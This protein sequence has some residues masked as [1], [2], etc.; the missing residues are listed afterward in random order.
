MTPAGIES[1]LGQADA[2]KGLKTLQ[3]TEPNSGCTQT[4]GAASQEDV[5]PLVGRESECAVLQ[6]FL[7]RTL[8]DC[9]P[10]ER[11]LYVS[12][13][14]GTGKT[15]SARAAVRRL[16]QTQVFEVNCMD[17]PQR[18][19]AGCS[20]QLAQKCIESLGG[21]SADHARCRLSRQVSP[22]GAAVEAL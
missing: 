13:G 15:C 16:P 2:D 12:G 4:G 11:C 9:T 19:V 22:I 17:L 10:A 21:R 6:T 1:I 20:D 18:S 14:P 3:P 7:Q 5:F 8:G